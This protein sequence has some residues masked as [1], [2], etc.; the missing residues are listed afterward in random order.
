MVGLRN[1]I[2]ELLQLRGR[3]ILQPWI[4]PLY[5][6]ALEPAEQ[7]WHSAAAMGEDETNIREFC[8]HSAIHQARDRS[9]RIGGVFNR[10]HRNS[11]N[12]SRAAFWLRGMHVNNGLPAIQLLVNGFEC[13]IAEVFVVKAGHQ[14]D[15]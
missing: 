15:T 2:V 12:K 13:L 9:S 14:T 1:F 10:R 8:R 5:C 6:K 7:K 11:R 4:F 3:A